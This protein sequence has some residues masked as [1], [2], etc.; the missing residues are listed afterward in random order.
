MECTCGSDYF[1]MSSVLQTS[2]DG[3]ANLMADDVLRP[4]VM[5]LTC[6]ACG[7]AYVCDPRSK[8]I[9]TRGSSAA[10]ELLGKYRL[11]FS[12]SFDPRQKEKV[13]APVVG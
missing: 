6:A 9:Y 1:A 7:N 12:E 13:D 11:D 4:W 5:H 8:T 2:K 3:R 10:M